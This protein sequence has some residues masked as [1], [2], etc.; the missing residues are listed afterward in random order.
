MPI[1]SETRELLDTI[2][3][4][5]WSK[6]VLDKLRY[7]FPKKFKVIAI[8]PYPLYLYTHCQLSFCTTLVSC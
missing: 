1:Q 6:V 3:V 4:N 5:I 7:F 2:P 8:N